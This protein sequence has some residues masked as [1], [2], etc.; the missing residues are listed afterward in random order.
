MT[1]PRD[2]AVI[3]RESVGHL[4]RSEMLRRIKA[5]MRFDADRMGRLE[6]N[7]FCQMG[8]KRSRSR[9]KARSASAAF[10]G[11]RNRKSVQNVSKHN[12]F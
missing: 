7:F 11:S 12:Y 9:R 8:R 2:L 6:R 5:E 4:A 10:L 1:A 3:L